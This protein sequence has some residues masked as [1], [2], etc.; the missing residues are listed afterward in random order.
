MNFTDS[1]IYKK[2]DIV[3]DIVIPQLLITMLENVDIV[4]ALVY[5]VHL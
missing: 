5:T 4:T 1:I 2:K 3:I